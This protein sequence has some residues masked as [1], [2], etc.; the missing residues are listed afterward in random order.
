[1]IGSIPHGWYGTARSSRPPCLWLAGVLAH[2]L[3][4]GVIRVHHGSR[5]ILSDSR[6]RA[7]RHLA[8]RALDRPRRRQAHSQPGAKNTRHGPPALSTTLALGSTMLSDRREREMFCLSDR[9]ALPALGT[10]APPRSSVKMRLRA[11]P[12][13]SQLT[14][15]TPAHDVHSNS[16]SLLT[17]CPIFSFPICRVS[18]KLY[19]E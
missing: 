5:L 8:P 10:R 6:E 2:S 16:M 18:S 17:S 3:I 13:R 15:I 12:H 11:D 19:T 14:Q 7:A 4:G 9:W 1:M